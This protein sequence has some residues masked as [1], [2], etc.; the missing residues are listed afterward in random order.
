L[1]LLGAPEFLAATINLADRGGFR[2]A[3]A[4]A[5]G[6]FRPYPCHRNTKRNRKYFPGSRSTRFWTGSEK[7]EFLLGQYPAGYGLL[8]G[9]RNLLLESAQ[10][11]TLM[12][13]STWETKVKPSA[14]LF[15]NDFSIDASSFAAHVNGF[16]CRSA[17]DA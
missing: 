14:A 7:P 10:E 12:S 3:I 4:A 15:H 13:V 11:A 5:G 2:A 9:G 1:T 17:L 6:A 16:N 8:G